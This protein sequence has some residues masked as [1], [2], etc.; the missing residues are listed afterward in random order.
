MRRILPALV[1]A[2]ASSAASA[3]EAEL[4]YGHEVLTRGTPWREL[5]LAAAF[6]DVGTPRL[7][8]AARDL[9]RFGVRDTE[10]RA[11]GSVPFAERWV[12]AAD[13]SGSPEHRFSPAFGAGVS[14]QRT[15]GGGF[16]ASAGA[17]GAA[18]DGDAGPVR[19]GVGSAGIERYF[20]AFRLGWTGYLATLHGRWSAANAAA[21]DL[22]YGEVGRVGIRAAA[23]REIEATGT[24][25]PIVSTVLAVGFAGR[26][27][28]GGAWSLT[29][30]AGVLRQG[31]LYTRTGARLGLR[32]Q[33]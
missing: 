30:D 33:F 14:L 8:L 7:E 6:G 18:Y 1:L 32:R 28:L 2:A 25:D 26:H 31:D 4:G 17:R 22:Y 9:E 10:L 13:A 29:W 11:G 23:G 15:L 3:S 12:V 16:V 24:G 19:T 27:G 5:A 20:G 21:L